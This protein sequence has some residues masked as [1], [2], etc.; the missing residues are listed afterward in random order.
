MR[1]R[2]TVGILLAAVVIAIMGP[3]AVLAGSK[4]RKTTA[5]ILTGVAAHQLLTGKTTNG[6]ILGAGAAYAWKRHADSRKAEKRRARS[7]RLYRA[8][9]AHSRYAYRYR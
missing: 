3:Q 7:A 9:Y 6:L 1:R 5:L 2:W 4:G 8:R